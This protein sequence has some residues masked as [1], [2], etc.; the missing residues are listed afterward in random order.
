MLL[1]HQSQGS[2]ALSVDESVSGEDVVHCGTDK[3]LIV[4]HKL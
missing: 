2:L 3:N 1:L 4:A